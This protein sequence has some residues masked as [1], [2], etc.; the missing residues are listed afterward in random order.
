MLYLWLF[1]VLFLG[2]WA[3]GVLAAIVGRARIGQGVSFRFVA[4][5]SG[6][7]VG[8]IYCTQQVMP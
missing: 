7:V 5:F 2:A 3:I 1:M 4:L 6:L 8:A